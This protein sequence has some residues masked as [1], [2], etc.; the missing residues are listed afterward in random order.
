V[1]N[2]P[3]RIK[4]RLL[5]CSTRLSAILVVGGLLFALPHVAHAQVNPFRGYKG[6]ALSKE[7]LA[8]AQAATKKLLT[9]DQA[10]VGKSEDWTGPASGNTGSISVQKTFQRKGMECRA[11]RSEVHYKKSPSSSP[12]ILNLNVCRNKTGEWKLV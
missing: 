1:T 5:G 8:S 4:A 12:K 9:E 6:P 3:V 11:L 7:D 10:Q 2:P